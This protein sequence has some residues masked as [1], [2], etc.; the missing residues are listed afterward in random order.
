MSDVIQVTSHIARDF[1]QNSAYFNT[2]PKVVWEYV[3]NGLDY[4]DHGISPIV[5]VILDSKQKKLIIAYNSYINILY[6]I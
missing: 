5:K 1:L 6:R 4:I 2:V 3:S